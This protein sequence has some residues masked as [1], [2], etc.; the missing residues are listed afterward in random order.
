MRRSRIRM[1]MRRRR[2]KRRRKRRRRGKRRRKRRGKRRGRR[3]QLVVASVPRSALCAAIL[4]N[5]IS[6]MLMTPC[7]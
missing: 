3:Q 7:P 4:S 6:H 1:R 5:T 2:R